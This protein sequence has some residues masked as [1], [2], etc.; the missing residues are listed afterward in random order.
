MLYVV[1]LSKNLPM[2][3]AAL[4][5]IMLLLVAGPAIVVNRDVLLNWQT[6]R[7]PSVEPPLPF[8]IIPASDDMCD[9]EPAFVRHR[10]AEDT[11]GRAAGE[12]DSAT[13]AP[14]VSAEQHGERAAVTQHAIRRRLH[15]RSRYD[16]PEDSDDSSI[17]LPGNVRW[18][19]LRAEGR[20]QEL[21]EAD[22]AR[23]AELVDE[24]AWTAESWG[25][26]AWGG[27]AWNSDEA[28]DVAS[29]ATVVFNRPMDEPIQ[30][31]PGRL[32]V[33]SGEAVGE[34]LRLFSRI[35]ETPRIIVGREP[36]APHSHLT[37]HS[38]T[39]S[40]RHA[41][42]DL[43][44]GRWVITNLSATN[45]VL[46]NDR[47]MRSGSATQQLSDGDRIDLGEVALRFVAG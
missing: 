25:T 44:A 3:L 9:I 19:E 33:L 18:A 47:V 7:R 4:F 27:D 14:P 29:D 32:H 12:T 36:G 11:P 17:E 45:P 38:P 41:R 39:V 22:V 8:L 6:S 30:M 23:E 26:S 42:L 15:R 24:Q 2:E 35:G 16:T 1:C 28:N 5:A 31:L 46:L 13:G 34:D 40:R 10:A 37:L 20:F 21:P 43:V